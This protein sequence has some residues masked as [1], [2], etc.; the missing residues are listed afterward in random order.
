ME[1]D[2]LRDR[3]N[4]KNVEC[5]NKNWMELTQQTFKNSRCR[6]AI[7]SEIFMMAAR[8]FYLMYI[9]LSAMAH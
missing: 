1:R 3:R 9:T 2:Q 4:L 5:A 8:I 7:A 6:V